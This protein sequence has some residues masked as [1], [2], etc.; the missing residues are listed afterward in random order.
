MQ[1]QAILG[2]VAGLDVEIQ[3]RSFEFRGTEAWWPKPRTAGNGLTQAASLAQR[4][5]GN[6][7]NQRH[8]YVFTYSRN[9][10]MIKNQSKLLRAYS[11]NYV[12]TLTVTR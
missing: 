1:W 10:D 2:D 12:N 6:T 8:A 7:A 4:S 5:G 3:T 9:S 11:Q